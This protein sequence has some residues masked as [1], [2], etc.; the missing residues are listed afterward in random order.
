MRKYQRAIAKHPN[1]NAERYVSNNS[2]RETRSQSVRMEGISSNINSDQTGSYFH[3]S[4]DSKKVSDNSKNNDGSN[5]T[6]KEKEEEKLPPII[7]DSTN[8]SKS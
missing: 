6:S 7:K 5:S 1:I 2:L 4:S 3:V 8:C